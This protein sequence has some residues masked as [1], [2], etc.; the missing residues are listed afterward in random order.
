MITF[1]ELV[2]DS[3]STSSMIRFYMISKMILIH[4][5]I[6][7]VLHVIDETLQRDAGGEKETGTALRCPTP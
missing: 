5:D 3:A 1:G 6:S 7:L 4:Y 2:L